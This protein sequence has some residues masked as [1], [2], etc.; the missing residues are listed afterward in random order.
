LGTSK[1]YQEHIAKE[2]PS[3]DMFS[4]YQGIMLGDG[5]IWFTEEGNLQSLNK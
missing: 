5:I 4:S 3:P 1:K 2:K